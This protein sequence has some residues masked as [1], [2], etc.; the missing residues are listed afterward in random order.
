VALPQCSSR[1]PETIT[2]G[3]GHTAACHQLGEPRR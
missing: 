1:M 3:P 2:L